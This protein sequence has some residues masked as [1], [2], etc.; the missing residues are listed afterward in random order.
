MVER[1]PIEAPT[2]LAGTRSQTSGEVDES[3][4]AN[5]IPYPIAKSSN[6]GNWVVNGNAKTRKHPAI[7]PAMIGLVLPILSQILPMN[8]LAMTSATI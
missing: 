5:E 8:G 7:M 3:T 2:K 1:K 4:L 6:K